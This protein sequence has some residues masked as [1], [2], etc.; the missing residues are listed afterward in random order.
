MEAADARAR[1][2]LRRE[3]APAEDVAVPTITRVPHR[4]K[5]IASPGLCLEPDRGNSR[6]AE[7][8]QE[9]L[10]GSSGWGLRGSGARPERQQSKSCVSHRH[11]ESS[12]W[13][14]GAANQIAVSFY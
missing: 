5:H 1:N 3:G 2:T 14:M 9:V 6:A 7:F 4:N 8:L 11:I 13:A 12:C 10:G